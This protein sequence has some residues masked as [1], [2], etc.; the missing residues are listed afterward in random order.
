M[1][2]D[3][4]IL[5]TVSGQC[6][7]FSLT[8]ILNR[9]GLKLGDFINIEI[10]MFLHK[11]VIKHSVYEEG[12]LISSVFL[13]LEKDGSY[14]MIL[15]LKSLNQYVTYYHFKMDS[16]WTAVRMMTPGCYMASNDLKDA[17]YSVHIDEQYQKYL[18]FS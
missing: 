13:R 6:I 14:R 5:E 7:E 18:N 17:C 1:T 10:L 16:I 12:E 2:S 15:N 8:N 11:R 3:R 4:E 9:T